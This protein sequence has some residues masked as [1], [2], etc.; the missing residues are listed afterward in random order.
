METKWKIKEFVAALDVEINKSL[1]KIGEEFVNT[2]KNKVP[3]ATGKLK[4]SIKYDKDSI[5]KEINL[6]S[7]LDYAIYVELGTKNMPPQSFLRST[8][9]EGKDTIEDNLKD[10]L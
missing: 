1:D 7:D 8:L 6:G 3:V 10:L 4:E 2:A 5:T 9:Y